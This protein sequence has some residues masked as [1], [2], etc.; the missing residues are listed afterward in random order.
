[1][2]MVFTLTN[3]VGRVNLG[4]VLEMVA[5]IHPQAPQSY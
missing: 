3:A 5:A 1:M 2:Q 4:C